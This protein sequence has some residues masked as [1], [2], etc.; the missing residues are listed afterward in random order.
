M[1]KKKTNLQIKCVYVRINRRHNKTE[2][3]NRATVAQPLIARAAAQH[4]DEHFPQHG[5]DS[6][7]TSELVWAAPDRSH[8]NSY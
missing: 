3:D 4:K 5:R 8:K 2:S 6:L 7:P 1:N